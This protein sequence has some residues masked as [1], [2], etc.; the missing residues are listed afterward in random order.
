[1]LQPR[2]RRPPVGPPSY[3][4]KH[5]QFFGKVDH[6]GDGR[7]DDFCKLAECLQV[8]FVPVGH[9]GHGRLADVLGL[10]GRTAGLGSVVRVSPPPRDFHRGG[11]ET[12]AGLG[13]RQQPGEGA[14]C[15]RLGDRDRDTGTGPPGR[16]Q[17]SPS[18]T[19]HPLTLLAVTSSR[20]L[21]D[22][23]NPRLRPPPPVQGHHERCLPCMHRACGCSAATGRSGGPGWWR[24]SPPPRV[25]TRNFR[26][27]FQWLPWALVLRWASVTTWISSHSSALGLGRCCSDLI[28]SSFRRRSRFSSISF[29]FATR[30]ESSSTTAG[31]PPPAPSA[32]TPRRAVPGIPI[33]SHGTAPHAQHPSLVLMLHQAPRSAPRRR[34]PCRDPRP[35]PWQQRVPPPAP[36]C[37]HGP[38]PSPRRCTS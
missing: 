31:S 13:A 1:M 26:F 10:R 28:I 37:T 2:P 4:R 18:V 20:T 27:C 14:V 35:S 23:P 8:D 12:E 22:V 21:G 30:L 6:A 16:A 7:G 34:Q 36:P 9:G 33:R 25:L 29:R 5:G 24:G 17:L 3:L 15:Q 11:G 32:G 19:A 38:W